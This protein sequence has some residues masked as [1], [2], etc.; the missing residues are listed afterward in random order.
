M[1]TPRGSPRVRLISSLAMLAVAIGGVSYYS[2]RMTGQL[3]ALPGRQI[4]KDLTACF[5]ELFFNELDF[6]FKTDAQ[7]MFFGV[8]TQIAQ[9]ILQFDDRFLEIELMFHISLNVVP[10]FKEAGNA[11]SRRVIHRHRP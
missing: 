8:L 9:L 1:N 3:H 7:R 4:G 5:F 11:E 6:L 2:V 10:D